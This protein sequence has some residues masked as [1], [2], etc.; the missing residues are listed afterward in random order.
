MLQANPHG[1]EESSNEYDD[2]DDEIA[3][4]TSSTETN[5]PLNSNIDP[6]GDQDNS[7]DNISAT[8]SLYKRNTTQPYPSTKRCERT[9]PIQTRVDST[10]R[11]FPAVSIPAPVK[12]VRVDDDTNPP[13]SLGSWQLPAEI[14][15]HI[16]TFLPPKM[17]GR[18]L[19]VNK[20]FNSFLDPLSKYACNSQVPLATASL[21][22]LKPEAIWQLSRRRFWPTMPTPLRDHTELQMW[23]L[24]RQNECKFHGRACQLIP[25][26]NNPSN[27]EFNHT[28]SRLIWSFALRSCVSC[29]VDRTIKEVDLFLSSSIPSCLI[30]ALPFTFIDDK[31]RIIPP[32]LLQTGHL[33]TKLPITKIFLSSHVVAIREEFA[34]VRAMGEATAE[35]WIK[36]LEGRGKEHRADSLRWEKFEMSGGLN[37]MLSS[38]YTQVD[39]KGSE[40]IRIPGLPAVVSFVRKQEKPLAL[41]GNTSSL[42]TTLATPTPPLTGPQGS[43]C[44]GSVR[45]HHIL[46]QASI[47]RSKTREEAEEKKAARRAEIERRAAGLKP[48]LP[49][50]IL[51]LCPS[52]QAAIQITSPLDDMAW[53]LLKPRLIAQRKDGDQDEYKKHE[54][55]THSE[56]SL[57]QLEDIQTSQKTTPESKQQVDKTWDDAQA[58]LR[59]HISVLA[60]QII[61][62]SWGNGRRINK[63]SSSQFAAEV[64][65][66]VREQFYA[67]VEKDDAAARAAGQ[68]P[69]CEA[70]NSPYTRKLTLE[71][72]KWLFDVKVKPLTESYRKE[73]FYCHDCEFNTKLYGFEGVVQHY[74][75]KHTNSLSFGNAVVHWRAEWPE[76]PPFHPEPYNLKHR[77][78]GLPSYKSNGALGVI[79]PTTPGQPLR[80]NGVILNYG[81]S[82]PHIQY[83]TV[84]F[85]PLHGQTAPYITPSWGF[86]NPTH[87]L[88]NLPLSETLY[89]GPSE[90]IHGVGLYIPTQSTSVDAYQPFQSSYIHSPSIDHTKLE[91]IIRNSR[92]LWVSL[93]PLKQLPGPLRI[94]VMIHHLST[95]FRARF[96]EEPSLALFIDGLS[97]KKEMRPIRNL[98]GLQCKACCRLGITA[99]AVQDKESYS[100]PQLVKHFQQRHIEQPYAIGAPVL[101]WC[102]DM[103]YLSL[104]NIPNLDSITNK[105]SRSLSLVYSAIS[106]AI[107][108]NSQPHTS[109]TLNAL[110]P[111][112]NKITGYGSHSYAIDPSDERALKHEPHAQHVEIIEDASQGN[113]ET[114]NED[115]GLLEATRLSPYPG[116]LHGSGVIN[117][118]LS[119]TSHR[120][121]H[122]LSTDI[123]TTLSTKAR[124]KTPSVQRPSP[125]TEKIRISNRELSETVGN[126]EDDGFDLIAGLESQLDRQASSAGLDNSAAPIK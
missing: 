3:F 92:E 61:C 116:R 41:L 1:E 110:S 53:N 74:A 40:A 7:K 79:P 89:H 69:I 47:I 95:R 66:Y 115:E 29:L 72:M 91:D 57:Q 37:R 85:Q 124:A 16:L 58:P 34:S 62:D 96:L 102:T 82:M 56:I 51:A 8:C 15:Q 4:E 108:R 71:N 93:A 5:S 42:D 119:K 64:L 31:M 55:S 109:R 67:E 126:D 70:L 6:F 10:K 123:T 97:N 86:Q 27:T 36:G 24:A 101:S 107:P 2:G 32:A 38:D 18:L 23:R 59:A 33:A 49:A 12:R 98:N 104:L 52:F 80:Q 76:V 75:A 121:T 105:D 17:L 63:E 21:I 83:D 20:S 99:T 14:W 90:P 120:S 54:M 112:D 13:Q 94:F 39:G 35:E 43:L 11:K 68:R 73:L 100:L 88:N 19:S 125:L 45:G 77:R 28:A 46:P 60:D 78:A 50:H 122:K 106:E 84:P 22:T 30:P 9:E 117:T 103:I 26:T 114:H 25:P 81:Q 87:N 118:P 113:F 48:P 111:V 44:A 65:L